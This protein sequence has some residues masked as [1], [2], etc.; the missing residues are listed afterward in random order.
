MDDKQAATFFI[1][2]GGRGCSSEVR[3]QG[4]V[5]KFIWAEKDWLDCIE[6][7]GNQSAFCHAIQHP[8]WSRQGVEAQERMGAARAAMIAASG[9]SESHWGKGEL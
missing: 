7:R 3:I 4:V 8:E 9:L 1:L 2:A 5:S 6:R